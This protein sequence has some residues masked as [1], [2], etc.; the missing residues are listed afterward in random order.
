VSAFGLAG[1]YGGAWAPAVPDVFGTRRALRQGFRA[2]RAAMLDMRALDLGEVNGNRVASVSTTP[3]RPTPTFGPR[4]HRPHTNEGP[5]RHQSGLVKPNSARSAGPGRQTTPAD[6]QD[7]LG[8][9]PGAD[10]RAGRIRAIRRV[11]FGSLWSGRR[12]VIPRR[13]V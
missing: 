4:A 2:L 3:S 7:H 11:R 9:F 12:V 10:F 5:T 6:S 8:P 13:S 1:V